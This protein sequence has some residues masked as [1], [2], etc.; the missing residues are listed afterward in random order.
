VAALTDGPVSDVDGY[1]VLLDG[2]AAG[3]VGPNAQLTLAGLEPGE[4]QVRLQQPAPGCSVD[5]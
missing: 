5:G 1:S 3:T 2:E 4:H